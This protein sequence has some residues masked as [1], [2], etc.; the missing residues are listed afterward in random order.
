MSPLG[1]AN[2]TLTF[3][4]KKNSRHFRLNTPFYAFPNQKLVNHVNK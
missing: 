1:L 4:G 2:V 3:R